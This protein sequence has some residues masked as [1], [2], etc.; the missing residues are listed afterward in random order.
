MRTC[1]HTAPPRFW[2]SLLRRRRKRY[3]S[4]FKALGSVANIIS[5]I[6]HH[7]YHGHVVWI[8]MSKI[9]RPSN[10]LCAAFRKNC[11]FCHS[12][13]PPSRP[14]VEKNKQ[15]A[16]SRTPWDT[17]S[18]PGWRTSSS[19]AKATSLGSPCP[20]PIE[21]GKKEVSIRLVDWVSYGWI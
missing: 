8:R 19:L 3:V 13:M 10:S 18:T 20:R 6:G 2:W 12:Q 16:P 7:L 5:S 1:W 11:G 15:I 9:T 17:A 14:Q 4:D 21:P